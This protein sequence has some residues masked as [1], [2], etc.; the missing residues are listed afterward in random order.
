MVFSLTV[1]ILL[2]V[3]SFISNGNLTGEGFTADTEGNVT[4]NG[5]T[6][7]F[8]GAGGGLFS[9]NLFSGDGLLITIIA[10]AGAGILAGIGLFGSGLSDTSQVILV[11]SVGFLGLWGALSI[12]SKPLIIDDTGIYGILIYFGLTMMFGIG[13]VFDIAGSGD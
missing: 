8:E 13:F 5:T 11:K 2:A 9:F 3:V 12:F 6:S 4:T 1:M 7:S 10:L